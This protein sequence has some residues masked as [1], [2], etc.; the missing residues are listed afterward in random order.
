M[1][2]LIACQQT[3][4]FVCASLRVTD[5]GLENHMYVHIVP[6]KLRVD[7]DDIVANHLTDKSRP[8]PPLGLG[9]AFS[10]WIRGDKK[11]PKIISKKTVSFISIVH[12]HKREHRN[13][14]LF[15]ASIIMFECT[16][17]GRKKTHTL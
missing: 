16:S 12:I 2:A 17:R 8:T 9:M 6:H 7:C 5:S 1:D 11:S 4:I 15:R 3:L 10:L 13:R 14:N